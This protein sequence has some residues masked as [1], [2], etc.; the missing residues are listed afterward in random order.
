VY[1]LHVKALD[2]GERRIPLTRGTG[3]IGRDAA[4]SVVLDQFGV[5]ARHAEV[6]LGAGR[7]VIRDVGS[8]NGTFVNGQRV[9][10]ALLNPGDRVLIGSVLLVVQ[11]AISDRILL[12]QGLPSGSPEPAPRAGRNGEAT[13]RRKAREVEPDVPPPPTPG[14]SKALLALV[15]RVLV[16]DEHAAAENQPWERHLSAL[17]EYF[18]AR[19]GFLVSVSARAVLLRASVGVEDRVV[20]DRELIEQ[21]VKTAAP[22]FHDQ[23]KT[24]KGFQVFLPLLHEGQAAAVAW[25]SVDRRRREQARRLAALAAPALAAAALALHGRDTR[26]RLAQTERALAGGAE[27]PAVA[28]PVNVPDDDLLGHGPAIRRVLREIEAL[29]QHDEP[30][31]IEGEPGSGIRQAARRIHAASSRA[32]RPFL[33]VN[34]SAASAEVLERVVFGGD[35]VSGA[36]GTDAKLVLAERGTLFLDEIADLSPAFQKRLLHLIERGERLP[37]DGGP[38]CPTDVRLIIGSRSRVDDLVAA[39]RLHAALFERLRGRRLTVP[40]LRD[41]IEDVVPLAQHMA[42]RTAARYHKRILGLSA[43]ACR[44]LQS[45]RWPGNVHELRQLVERA[46]LLAHDPIL[47]LDVLTFAGGPEDDSEDRR[48]KAIM[49]TMGLPWKEAKLAFEQM[50]FQH[51]LK[52]TG[53]NVARSARHAGMARKNFYT[54]LRQHGLLRQDG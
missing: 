37:S 21:A 52:S 18:G 5:S 25:L 41:R 31:L 2:G 13:R 24:G 22:V 44:V 48:G 20:V 51:A 53:G 26:E 23:P 50:Y 3:T 9:S 39:G 38:G 10:D 1:Y 34:C 32:D 36:R 4:N 11:E 42:R 47:D 35:T 17:I 54:K 30:A 45:H 12:H 7:L 28:G 15:R 16:H 8:T 14:D 46:V 29:G 33:A 19:A 43:E 49:P 27:W 6:E 40:P